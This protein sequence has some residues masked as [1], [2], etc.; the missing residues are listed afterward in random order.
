LH[1]GRPFLDPR[2]V[3]FSLALPHD[4]R[5]V[6]GVAKPLLQSAMKGILPEPIR[7]RKWKGH[8]NDVYR[9]GLS[10]QLGALEDMVRRSEIRELDLL[11]SDCLLTALHQV[12]AGL[13]KTTAGFRLNS[14]LAL[15]AWYD[16][17]GPALRRPADEPT[18]VVRAGKERTK[19]G[20]A[21]EGSPKSPAFCSE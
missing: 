16:Q 4:L 20:S 10:R 5:L 21:D 18:A 1:T 7:T 19:Q 12:A 17:L 8:F 3:A 11:D 15:V 13:G 9:L 6:P 14:T 2:L